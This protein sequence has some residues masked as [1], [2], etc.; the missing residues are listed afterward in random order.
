MSL[1]TCAADGCTETFEFDPRN[2]LK[3]FHSVQCQ[4]RTRVSRWR[5]ARKNGPGG[6][7]GKKRQMALFSKQSVSAKRIKQPRPETAP[8]FTMSANGK[9]EKHVPLLPPE[10]CALP[11]IGHSQDVAPEADV[12]KPSTAASPQPQVEQ[13]RA[14]AA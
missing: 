10:L 5:K 12:R 7:G 8:L 6:G 2:P 11:V 9:H 13:A 3:Q 14:V 4:T 1:R